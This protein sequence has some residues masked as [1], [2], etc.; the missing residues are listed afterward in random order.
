[1]DSELRVSVLE[2]VELDFLKLWREHPGKQ[3][4]IINALRQWQREGKALLLSSLPMPTGTGKDR[5]ARVGH[6]IKVPSE[7]D[8]DFYQVRLTPVTW[9]E[10]WV[11]MN[12][13]R[14]NDGK[15]S[16]IFNPKDP[17]ITSWPL[18]WPSRPDP[19]V[20]SVKQYDDLLE[21]IELKV[22][23]A[24]DGPCLLAAFRPADAVF[25]ANGQSTEG[26]MHVAMIEHKDDNAKPT[27]AFQ[28]RH[29][30]SIYTLSMASSEAF[31]L[32]MTRNPAQDEALLTSLFNQ[33]ES[34]HVTLQ[35]WS[36][37]AVKSGT[38]S[39]V[40]SARKHLYPTEMPTIPSSWG[41]QPVGGT[42][43]CDSFI[44]PGVGAQLDLAIQQ[45]LTAPR[46]AIWPLAMDA[47]EMVMR[48]PQFVTTKVNTGLTI[49]MN[50]TML[51]S[52][53]QPPSSITAKD[54]LPADRTVLTFAIL[55][56]PEQKTVPSPPPTDDPFSHP[57]NRPLKTPI[58]IAAWVTEVPLSE[59]E[60]WTRSIGTEQSADM[61]KRL[62]DGTDRLETLA[63]VNTTSGRP[64]SQ[65][66]TEEVMEVTE[67]HPAEN[68]GENGPFN[69]IRPTAYNLHPTGTQWKVNLSLFADQITLNYLFSHDVA[70]P[71]Q[72]TL[73]EMIDRF[74]PKQQ[75]A[76]EMRKFQQKWQGK[77]VL[78]P[79]VCRLVEVRVVDHPAGQRLHLLWLRSRTA[80]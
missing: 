28:S 74:Y 30:L 72:P 52:A 60:Q 61:E 66:L 27:Q 35:A 59:K 80:Q 24:K 33:L 56:G 23:P 47:P 16:M 2:V 31:R 69:R 18:T 9:H 6:G 12:L 4:D 36:I 22:P 32:L 54:G 67:C 48:L 11:G 19:F 17:I 62:A 79:D 55:N 3:R 58:E 64:S 21:S 63:L 44:T 20:G 49:G 68:N 40:M 71:I 26:R 10:R 13:S 53:G 46:H 25:P 38:R 75:N 45:H 51:I 5:Q 76:P 39:T 50:Q 73:A 37:A 8:Q 42:F 43:E 57:A 78:E 14:E 29:W 65:M 34:G 70:H 41:D 1:M 15:L 77:I 7:N